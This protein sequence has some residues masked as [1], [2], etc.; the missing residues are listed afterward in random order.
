LII[1]PAIDKKGAPSYVYRK[2]YEGALLYSI[3]KW[4]VVHDYDKNYLRKS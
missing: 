2:I 4:M 3:D 1:D